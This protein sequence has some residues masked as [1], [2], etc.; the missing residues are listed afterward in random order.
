[1]CCGCVTAS[2]MLRAA[3]APTFLAGLNAKIQSCLRLTTGVTTT[4]PPLCR[5]H[6]PPTLFL[7]ARSSQVVVR[8]HLTSPSFYARAHLATIP[9]A[10]DPNPFLASSEPCHRLYFASPYHLAAV[11]TRMP[12]TPVLFM[13]GPTMLQSQC[14]E[15]AHVR[16]QAKPSPPHLTSPM[17]PL[18]CPRPWPC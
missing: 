7:D 12:G 17:M 6:V 1:M 2:A 4:S 3:H 13:H 5:R 18:A 9:L 16:T 10:T 14:Q 15:F 11:A 8:P